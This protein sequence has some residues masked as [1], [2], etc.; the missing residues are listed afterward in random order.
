MTESLQFVF[1][2]LTSVLL[3]PAATDPFTPVSLIQL[4]STDFQWP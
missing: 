4:D 2:A 3:S 1:S